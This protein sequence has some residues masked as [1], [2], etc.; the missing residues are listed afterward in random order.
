M[1]AEKKAGRARAIGVS[2]FNETQIQRL[3]DQ[4][5]VPP[6][7]LQVELHV[8][9]QQRPLVDFCKS[10]GISVTA[11]SPIGSPGSKWVSQSSG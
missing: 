5:S 8:Q 9:H 2:N 1:E 10:K 3:L 4:G 6:A 11:Y 7:N